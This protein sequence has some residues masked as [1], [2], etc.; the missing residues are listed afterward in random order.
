MNL[1]EQILADKRAEVEV[2]KARLPMAQLQRQA[3]ACP[4]RVRLSAA[5]RHSRHGLG[6]IAEVK[7]RSPSAGVIREP[8]DPAAI[9]QT[10]QAAGAEGLSVLMDTKYFGGGESDFRA[11]R[12]AVELPLLYKEFVVDPWQAWH[13]RL[14]GAS[15]VLLIVGAL[16]GE[17]LGA[18]LTA[19]RETGLEALVEVHDE[20]EAR[21]AVDAGAGFIG[22]N[23]RDLKTFTTSLDVTERILPLLP[24]EA[25][26]ISESGIRTV[27]DAARLHRLGVH[28]M[29][30]GEHLLREPDIAASVKG[31]RAGLGEVSRVH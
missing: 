28:G 18:M 24:K 11:V 22:I 1:L 26:R 15:A 2:A 27:E 5:L 25:T 14:L 4:I 6:L 31:L 8:F 17:H 29:L 19:V 23:N 21:R 7:R 16:P 10:Y 9:A 30:V 12:A 13:A 3:E 20:T